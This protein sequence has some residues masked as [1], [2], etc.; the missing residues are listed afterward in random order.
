MV[1]Q[2]GEM[3]NLCDL[4][5]SQGR[6]DYTEPYSVQKRD[7]LSYVLCRRDPGYQDTAEPQIFSKQFRLPEIR[8][9]RHRAV[10]TVPHV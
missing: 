2:A 7:K 1:H 9:L 4:T 3:Y 8:T 5:N 6:V 10:P